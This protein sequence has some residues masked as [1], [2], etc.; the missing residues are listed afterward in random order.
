MKMNCKNCGHIVDGNFCSHCGQNSSVGRIDFSSFINDVSESIFQINRGF[1]Y[2]LIELSTRPGRSID[3]FLNGKRK[4]HFKPI[5]YVLLLSTVY[6]LITQITK[7][8]TW[9]DD[10]VSGWMNGAV[11]ES[12]DVEI[13]KFISWF[14]GNFAYTTLLLL[15][16]FSFASYLT[17]FKFGKT[18]LE[19]IVINA[20]LTGHQAF[21]YSL[22]AIAGTLSDSDVLQMASSLLAV[23]YAFWVFLQLFSQGS[24]L[25]NILRLI[26]AYLLYFIFCTVL[27]V[28]LLAINEVSK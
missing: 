25:F 23:S 13:P 6:F 17:F 20:Y 15:P 12:D 28:G 26:M 21:I 7:Q 2:T 11:E 10:V 4:N 18:Y 16:L 19:H 27:L 9:L 3:E 5:A 22:F 14:M 1:I 8:N 24:R